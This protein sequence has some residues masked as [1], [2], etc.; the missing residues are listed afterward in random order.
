MFVG[1][2]FRCMGNFSWGNH[3][4]ISIAMTSCSTLGALFPGTILLTTH[5]PP[6]ILNSSAVQALI[7]D[8]DNAHAHSG[9]YSKV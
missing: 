2:I 7:P 8:G 5:E 9:L 3:S 1:L 4:K 6:V